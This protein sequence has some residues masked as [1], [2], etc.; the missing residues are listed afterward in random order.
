MISSVWAEKKYFVIK[1]SRKE[2]LHVRWSYPPEGWFKLNSD[3]ASYGNPGVV[4]S[5]GIIRN[6][7]GGWV[8]AYGV[9]VGH[10]SN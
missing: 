4:G 3:G 8:K 6:E 5:G 2:T 9:N 10:C 1:G 7:A